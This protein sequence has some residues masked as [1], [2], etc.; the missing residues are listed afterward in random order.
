MYCFK[1]SLSP[2]TFLLMQPLSSFAVLTLATRTCAYKQQTADTNSWMLS[3]FTGSTGMLTLWT[4][5][6][7]K[8]LVV[9]NVI[10]MINLVPCAVLDA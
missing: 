2:V 8:R 5:G 3:H 4:A 9:L 1:P 10:G 6:L 7:M